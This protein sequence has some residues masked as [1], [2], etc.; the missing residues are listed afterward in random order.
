MRGLLAVAQGAV[1]AGGAL[2]QT[3]PVAGQG[4]QGHA[5]APP[6]PRGKPVPP[7]T[8]EYRAAADRMHKDM[9]LR[10]SGD[11][12]KD[13]VRGMIPHHQGAVEMAR[14]ELKYGKDPE[15]RKL[16]EDVIAAQEKEIAFM[17]A[18]LAQN[19]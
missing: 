11:A 7:S 2:A 3:A 8:A 9:A 5:H 1:L 16:A 14:I 6:A 4:M 13:F 10:Y 15:L 19:P 18:W 12:D 17:N